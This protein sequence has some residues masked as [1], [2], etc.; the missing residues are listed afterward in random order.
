MAAFHTTILSSSMWNVAIYGVVLVRALGHTVI[1]C[2][3]TLLAS[4]F[5]H[6]SLHLFD[7][8]WKKIFS[9]FLFMLFFACSKNNCYPVLP[10]HLQ[11]MCH[12]S[13]CTDGWRQTAST[14]C[15]LTLP[16]KQIQ[17][18]SCSYAQNNWPYQNNFLTIGGYFECN[19]YH[20]VVL[21]LLK[22][23]QERK[24]NMNNSVFLLLL[25]TGAGCISCS[26]WEL[27]HT[28]ERLHGLM[29]RTVPITV[30]IAW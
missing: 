8:W 3:W 22:N 25:Q 9:T 28:C 11:L 17:V 10:T 16:S 13:T 21:G 5:I 27:E 24:K 29:M 12:L 2:M 14:L 30:E 4:S 23:R 26:V 19:T 18:V 6:S 20:G 7:F 15:L 1:P